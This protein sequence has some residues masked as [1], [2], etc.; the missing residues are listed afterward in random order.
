LREIPESPDAE[1]DG[2][3]EEVAD[4]KRKRE[5][6]YARQKRIDWGSTLRRDGV[7]EAGQPLK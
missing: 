1:L 6:R 3:L 2:V 4:L 5:T 7:I